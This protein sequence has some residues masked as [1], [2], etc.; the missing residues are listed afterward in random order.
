MLAS[1]IPSEVVGNAE[2]QPDFLEA[3]LPKV[4]KEQRSAAHRSS[5]RL[6]VVAV[7]IEVD[8]HDVP[9]AG[10]FVVSEIPLGLADVG[11]GAVPVVAEKD[12]RFTDRNLWGLHV[13]RNAVDDGA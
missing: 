10:A 11:E 3:S 5:R 8:G 6:R 9:H 7:L 13:P 1:S 2:I 12:V 4:L